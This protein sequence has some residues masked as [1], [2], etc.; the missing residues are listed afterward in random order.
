VPKLGADIVLLLPPAEVSDEAIEKM[1]IKQ[2]RSFL[3]DRGAECTGCAEKP[4]FVK[5]AKETKDNPV[6]TK[7]AAAEPAQP[8]PAKEKEKPKKDA[9]PSPEGMTAF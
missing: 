2:L 5:L 8:T 4:D 6:I 7:P 1:S 9:P 3:L